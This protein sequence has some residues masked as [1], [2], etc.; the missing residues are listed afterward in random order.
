MFLLIHIQ[1]YNLLE[2][3][4]KITFNKYKLKQ[5]I[6][7]R[8]LTQINCFCGCDVTWSKGCDQEFGE[9]PQVNSFLTEIRPYACMFQIVMSPGASVLK[10]NNRVSA[11]EI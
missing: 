1:F 9:P 6:Y 8:D 5:L 10:T 4:F 2:K 11:H 3:Q 7:K